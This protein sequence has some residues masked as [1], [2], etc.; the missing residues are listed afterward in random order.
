MDGALDGDILRIVGNAFQREK[1]CGGR[2]RQTGSQSRVRQFAAYI[3][4]SAKWLD[5]ELLSQNL[6]DAVRR[7]VGSA[8]PLS[9]KGGQ[10][11]L[12][13]AMRRACRFVDSFIQ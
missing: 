12:E 2:Y 13:E 6:I 4:R 9:E 11:D 3:E 10:R 7:S 5:A 8:D 1:R